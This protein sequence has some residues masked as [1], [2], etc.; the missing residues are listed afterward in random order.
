MNEIMKFFILER[1][2]HKRYNIDE[3]YIL[4]SNDNYLEY[5]IK[6]YQEEKIMKIFWKK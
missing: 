1:N 6:L 2:I 5:L 4:N 3:Y